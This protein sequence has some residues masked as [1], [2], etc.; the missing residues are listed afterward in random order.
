MLREAFTSLFFKTKGHH[1]KPPV[2]WGVKRE[3]SAPS[4][5]F[6]APGMFRGE[7]LSRVSERTSYLLGGSYPF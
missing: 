1:V 7:I 5:K 3:R 6:L 2:L 4:F